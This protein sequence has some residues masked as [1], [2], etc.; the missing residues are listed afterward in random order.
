M[1]DGIRCLASWLSEPWIP[2]LAGSLATAA[3]IPEQEKTFVTDAG[4]IRIVCRWDKARRNEPA[5]LWLSWEA[6]N[7]GADEELLI[8][9]VNPETKEVRYDIRLRNIR[10][11]EETFTEDE[12][13]FDPS[14]VPWGII[15]A[16]PQQPKH[17]C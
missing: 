5:Y 2:E 17:Q 11:G 9:L 10:A 3:D 8:R 1:A 12:M 13:G 4:K 14:A 15:A 16:V 7:L 6:E